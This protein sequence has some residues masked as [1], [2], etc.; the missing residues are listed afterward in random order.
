ME[1]F[2]PVLVDSLVMALINKRM[3]TPNG[4]EV[5]L[6]R[7]HKMKKDTLR[8]FLSAYEEKKRSEIKHPSLGYRASYWRSLELQARIL[9]KVLMGELDRYVPFLIR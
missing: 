6:G 1:E 4:F 9:A 2:R 7:V 8:T 3:V 5:G